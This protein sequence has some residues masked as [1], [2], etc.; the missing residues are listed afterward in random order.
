MPTS[1]SS[2][3]SQN[4][5]DRPTAPASGGAAISEMAKVRPM[6]APTSAMPLVR[7][8]SRVKSASSAVTAA[9]MAPAPCSA[10][11]ATSTCT[12]PAMAATALPSANTSRPSTMIFLRPKRSDARPSGTC[13]T[14][15]LSPYTPMASPISAG[16]L[17]PG[18]LA[19]SSMNTGSTR[20]SP[21]MRSAKIAAID[22]LARRS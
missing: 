18:S 1:A 17:P 22:R 14:A 6:L 2:A 12:L 11:P 16:S 4:R 21:S 20:N 3:V 7:T 13:M 8:S 10:R 9:D 5:P 19:A 15:W